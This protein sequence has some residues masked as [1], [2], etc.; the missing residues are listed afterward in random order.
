M[1]WTKDALFSKAKLFIEKAASEDKDSSYYGIFSALALELLARAALANVHP[2]LLADADA[3]Q[4]NVLYALGHLDSSSNPKSIMTKHVITICGNLI[5]DFNADLQKL[6]LS[7]TE[8]R[9]E[10]LHSGGAAFLE[11]DQDQWIGSFYKACQVLTASMGESLVSFLGKKRA[12][13]AETLIHESDVKIRKEVSDKISARK[14]IYEEVLAVDKK[15]IE[16]LLM[17]SEYE[18]RAKTHLGYHRVN[19]PCCGNSATIHG[20]ESSDSHDEIKD[21]VVIVRKDVIPDSFSCDVCGLRLSSYAELQAANL[22]LHYTN[23]YTYDPIE[24]FSIDVNEII[25]SG[26][27]EEYSNE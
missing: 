12:A 20:K 3:S 18:I 5:P 19:C 8:R 13:E 4:K 25:A 21:D 17:R 7:M 6:A 16:D 24:Y 9:N 1:N 27:L 23:T 14:R 26:Y 2:T 22:P 10:E 15:K 11:Y